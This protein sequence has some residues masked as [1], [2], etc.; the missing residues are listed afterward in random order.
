MTKYL[1]TKRNSIEDAISSVV[2]GEGFASDAQRRAAFAQGYKAKGKKDKSEELDEA[3]SQGMFLVIQGPGDNNQKVISMHK[4]KS[5]AIKAR[6][7]WNEKNGDSVKKGK[8]GKPMPAH[9]ARV[10]EVGKFATT[11]GK[12]KTFKVGDSVIYS[13]FARSIV[14]EEVELGEGYESE[15]EE[16]LE[17]QII[18]VQT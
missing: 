12:P 6:D 16:D 13:D 17:D 14:K 15:V 18:E 1:E 10:Y 5:D 11:N 9:L 4:R 7:K 3:G 8:S 2:K